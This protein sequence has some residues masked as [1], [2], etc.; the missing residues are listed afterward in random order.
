MACICTEMEFTVSLMEYWGQSAD[1]FLIVIQN[2]YIY[3]YLQHLLI[4]LFFSYTQLSEA[5]GGGGGF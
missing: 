3:V 4:P 1:H 5:G 2:T